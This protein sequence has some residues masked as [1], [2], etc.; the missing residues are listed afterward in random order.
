MLQT[1]RYWELGEQT[2]GE[3]VDLEAAS[4]FSHSDLLATEAHHRVGKCGSSSVV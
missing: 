2:L 4:L 1:C 3:C